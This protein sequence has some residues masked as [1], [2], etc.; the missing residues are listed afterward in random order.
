MVTLRRDVAA[1][2]NQFDHADRD[3][4]TPY[5]RF[6]QEKRNSRARRATSYPTLHAGET[7]GNYF[8]EPE[9]YVSDSK[10]NSEESYISKNYS[11]YL[12]AQINRTAPGARVLSED[13]FYDR[14]SDT[15]AVSASEAASEV[16]KP[17]IRKNRQKL[18]K[19]GKIF[20][21]AYVLV[22]A[23]VASIIIAVNT[24]GR[25]AAVDAGNDAEYTGRIAPMVPAEEPEQPTNWFDSMLDG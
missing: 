20:I 4:L 25:P 22:V 1:L 13:E 14:Y 6:Q 9:H 18:G 15:K 11:E 12:A 10:V 8:A 16:K 17:A 21:A 7:R 5:D 2:Y 3:V 19:R 24:I 23:I